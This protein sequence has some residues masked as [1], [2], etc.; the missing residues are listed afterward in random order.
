M[1]V[2]TTGLTLVTIMICWR[3]LYLPLDMWRLAWAWLSSGLCAATYATCLGIVA[4]NS[5]NELAVMQMSVVAWTVIILDSGFVI[6]RRPSMTH[7]QQYTHVLPSRFSAVNMIIC[8]FAERSNADAESFLAKFNLDDGGPSLRHN[9]LALSLEFAFA[10]VVGLIGAGYGLERRCTPA[11]TPRSYS[12][13]SMLVSP[14]R[15]RVPSATPV[16]AV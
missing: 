1:T 16:D 7:W 2:V 13:Y 11:D 9:A 10:A 6:S 14:K 4:M 15:S 12:S 8:A 3:L 5:P